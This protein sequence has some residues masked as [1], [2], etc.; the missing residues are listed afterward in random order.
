MT[1]K[2]EGQRLDSLRCTGALKELLQIQ[3]IKDLLH[4]VERQQHLNT[5]SKKY[6]ASLA[7]SLASSVGNFLACP[8]TA[9]PLHEINRKHEVETVNMQLEIPVEHCELGQALCGKAGANATPM[10]ECAWLLQWQQRGRQSDLDRSSCDVSRDLMQQFLRPRICIRASS[11]G[12]SDSSSKRKKG[13]RASA[14][15]AST[16]VL[17]EGSL[18]KHSSGVLKKWQRRYFTIAGH[19]LK[20]GTSREAVVATPKAVIDLNSLTSCTIEQTVLLE[21][22]FADRM[23]LELQAETPDEAN[24]WFVTLQLFGGIGGAPGSAARASTRRASVLHSLGSLGVVYDSLRR[25]RR[26]TK[27]T[28]QRVADG[29]CAALWCSMYGGQGAAST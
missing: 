16:V 1:T 28:Q 14:V 12:T 23:K 7:S 2:F 15:S 21:L 10:R 11:E 19:Y 18:M 27:D 29:D 3:I 9:S 6:S 20:Y 25:G 24:D 26:A 5:S 22:E 13:F 4:E 17:M 8:L